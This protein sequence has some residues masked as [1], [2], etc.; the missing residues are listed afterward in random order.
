M[1]FFDLENELPRWLDAV[2]A[3][4]Q[5]KGLSEMTSQTDINKL[6]HTSLRSYHSL[7][8]DKGNMAT[9][10]VNGGSHIWKFQAPA[11]N[12][13]AYGKYLDFNHPKAHLKFWL[14][15][16]VIDKSVTM[17]LWFGTVPKPQIVKQFLDRILVK[18]VE[19]REYWYS[20]PQGG[21][22]QTAATN[23]ILAPFCGCG[24]LPLGEADLKKLENAI[25]D[26]A[27]KLLD[28]VVQILDAI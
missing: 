4:Y 23:E 8:A 28:A 9:G 22:G 13:R 3:P 18:E 7:C 14:G 16:V 10:G 6:D 25:K 1:S 17:Y 21:S 26:A 5:R 11:G 2:I 20:L 24:V 12:I 27:Q 19:N 15:I